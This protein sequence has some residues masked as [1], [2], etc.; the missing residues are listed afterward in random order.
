MFTEIK[1]QFNDE[2]IYENGRRCQTSGGGMQADMP[3]MF[4]WWRKSTAH[5]AYN[6]R[7]ALDG[8]TSWLPAVQFE[9]GKGHL[10]HSRLSPKI[11][12][13]MGKA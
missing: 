9:G 4:L 5:F 2:T 6:L 3:P 13:V 7:V 10:S 1:L 12:T 11:L 8:I